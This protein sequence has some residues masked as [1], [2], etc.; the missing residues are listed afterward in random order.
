MEIAHKVKPFISFHG[1]L[2]YL[3]KKKKRGRKQERETDQKSLILYSLK[4][5]N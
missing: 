3:K 4:V 5:T 2:F 1:K